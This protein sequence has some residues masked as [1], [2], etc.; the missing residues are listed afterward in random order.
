MV[1][2]L[3][4]FLVVFLLMFSGGSFG[5]EKPKRDTISCWSMGDNQKLHLGQEI[6]DSILNKLPKLNCENLLK[7]D[8]PTNDLSG[9]KKFTLLKL[10]PDIRNLSILGSEMPVV[11]FASLKI[12]PA[13]LYATSLGFFCKKELQLDKITSV[14]IRFRL[15]SMEYVSFMEGKTL[16]NK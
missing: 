4:G 10:M 1:Q 14:P 6:L 8:C 11:N 3:G 2:R 13:S 16:Y 7:T 9:Y 5:Q 12:I 15:G